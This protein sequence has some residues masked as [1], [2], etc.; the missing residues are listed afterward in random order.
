VKQSLGVVAEDKLI[1]IQAKILAT[2]SLQYFNRNVRD[3]RNASWAFTHE[4][5]SRAGS[6]DVIDAF[7]LDKAP[8]NNRRDN[9]PEKPRDLAEDMAD[10]LSS[11]GVQVRRG[12]SERGSLEA[13]SQFWKK[14]SKAQRATLVALDGHSFD[15]HADVKRLADLEHGVHSMCLQ[16]GKIPYITKKNAVQ[17]VGYG[18]QF[19]SNYALKLNLKT[20]G[21]N[22]TLSSDFLDQCLGS[23]RDTTLILGADVTHPNVGD[24]LGTPSIACVVGSY[25]NQ[26][27]IYHGSMRLQAGR[28]EV[29][30][31]I[32][33]EERIVLTQKANC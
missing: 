29:S 6:L 27:Q 33:R 12:E 31:A 22:H 9:H 11:H 26:F 24:A 5:F 18:Y 30:V 13:L 16:S 25:D 14:L 15:I 19:L 21:I 17:D 7:A 28:E 10:R 2:P 1:N 4:R 8:F 32:T 23:D 20:G 3:I